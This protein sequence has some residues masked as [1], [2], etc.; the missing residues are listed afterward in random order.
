M[1]VTATSVPRSPS[2]GADLTNVAEMSRMSRGLSEM[3]A[4]MSKMSTKRPSDVQDVPVH[5]KPQTAQEVA[6]Q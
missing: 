3:S 1:T 4:Q 6:G 5:W 2:T